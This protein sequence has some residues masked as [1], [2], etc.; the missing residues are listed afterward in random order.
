MATLAELIQQE[1]FLKGG[2]Q[3][4]GGRDI[5]KIN[6]IFKSVAGVGN[7]LG[8]I[9]KDAIAR[10][11]TTREGKSLKELAPDFKLPTGVPGDV[12]LEEAAKFAKL[13][14]KV[15]K[16]TP[17]QKRAADLEIQKAQEGR[18]ADVKKLEK[19]EKEIADKAS[20]DAKKDAAKLKA[21]ALVAK[22][23]RDRDVSK[24][25]L[26]RQILDTRLKNIDRLIESEQ[27]S[28]TSLEQKTLNISNLENLRARKAAELDK[29]NNRLRATLNV[30]D[31]GGAQQFS[32]DS[33]EE[34]ERSGL[35]TGTEITIQG[36]RAVIE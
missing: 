21:D 7:T 1:S 19:D 5:D 27:T 26:E 28:P 29:L 3:P 2:G 15:L 30:G 34:A 12:T 9:A 24:I 4:Q 10:R 23:R 20:A 33:V 13:R 36:R 31:A 17:A 14:P 11:K 8:D 25:K 22:Q 32:F 35:P 6:Q 16:E 18:K